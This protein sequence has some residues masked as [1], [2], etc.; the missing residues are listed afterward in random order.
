MAKKNSGGTIRDWNRNE[1]I[2]KQLGHR[3]TLIDRI[4]K[5]RLTWFVHVVGMDDE[6]L[7]TKALY[8]HLGKHGAEE[9]HQTHGRFT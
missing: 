2:R 5:R 9:V 7:P 3:E 4:R 6:R 8:C 1:L